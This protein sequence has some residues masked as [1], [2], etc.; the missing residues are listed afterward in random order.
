[1]ADDS[2]PTSGFAPHSSRAYRLMLAGTVLLLLATLTAAILIILLV[3]AQERSKESGFAATLTALA[4]AMIFAQPD[5]V[6][7]PDPGAE[8]VD[9]PSLLVA[10]D[11][12]PSFAAADT[13]AEQVVAGSVL[14]L[15]GQPTDAFSV[16]AWGDYVAPRMLL[17]GEIAGHGAGEWQVAL[18]GGVNRRVWVQVTAGGRTLS[19]PVEIVFTAD[20]CAR[21]LATVVFE[22]HEPLDSAASP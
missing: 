12:S 5:F 9:A 3:N 7:S 21:N 14:N 1:M 18:P 17:S 15:S 11:D 8:L 13:C 19:A 10:S 20:D 6:P 2:H 16:L 22:Q 4:P